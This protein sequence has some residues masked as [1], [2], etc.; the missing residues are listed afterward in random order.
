MARTRIYVLYD[1]IT[2]SVFP[3]QVLAPIIAWL[4]QDT[5]HK[6]VLISFEKKNRASTLFARH[7]RLSVI[8]AKKLAFIGTI[9]LYY[10]TMQLQQNLRLYHEYDLIARGPLAGWICLKTLNSSCDSI[11]IQ[12]RGLLAEEYAYEHGN[13][14]GLFHWLH[15]IRASQMRAIEHSVF[16]SKINNLFF[17]SVSPALKSYLMENF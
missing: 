4:D 15:R 2:N 13:N 14:R 16:S 6:A 1:S 11:T 3:S 9:S 5:L 7:N 8:I 17:E 12:V 10:A